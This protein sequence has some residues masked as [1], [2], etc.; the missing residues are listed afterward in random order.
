MDD[1]YD[2]WMRDPEAAITEIVGDTHFRNLLDL[3]PYREYDSGTDTRRWQDFMSGDWAWD[4]AVSSGQILFSFPALL[5]TVQDTIAQ[6]PT[7]HGALM[8]PI[9]LGSDKTTVSVTTGQHDYYPL[10]LSVGNLHNTARCAHKNG[11]KLI[12]FLAMPKSKLTEPMLPCFFY[13]FCLYY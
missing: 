11:V 9:I 2:V 4:E 12:A 10:Y 3:V 7:T 13:L 8:I 1:V 6:N 5:R